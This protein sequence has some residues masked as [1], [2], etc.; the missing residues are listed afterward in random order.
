MAKQFNKIKEVLDR[1]GTIIERTEELTGI[2]SLKDAQKRRAQK[3]G[4][5]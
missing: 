2:N 3:L 4:L 5:R 1:D